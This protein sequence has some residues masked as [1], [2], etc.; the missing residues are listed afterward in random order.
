MGYYLLDHPPARSQYRSSR[1][2][3]PTG[4]IC[5]HTAE[6]ILDLVG[7]D[8]GAES[9][10]NFISV[11]T[12]AAGSYH[13]LG[14]RD[15]IVEMMPLSYEAFG[16]ATGSNP[17]GIHISLAMRAADWPGLSTT[18]RD[19]LLATMVQMAV[20]AATWVSETFGIAVPARRLTKAESDRGLAGFI[21]HGDR[22]PARRTDPGPAFPWG[23]FLERFADVDGQS[24]PGGPMP[25]PING[26]IAKWQRVLLSHGA[27]LGT[28]GPHGDGVDDVFGDLTLSQSE[29][30]LGNLAN[31]IAELERMLGD[32]T[33]V[34]A[35]VQDRANRYDQ[36]LNALGLGRP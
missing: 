28:S 32:G 31:R 12:D 14:D 5:V 3:R 34:P 16:D 26:N 20:I 10:A 35:D 18:H 27:Q 15:S 4:C 33:N 36:I 6:N 25:D 19:Q 13:I 24:Q 1:R 2:A 29:V 11:R 22:D 21:A 23:L 17:W 7:A 8:S 9:V 30:V